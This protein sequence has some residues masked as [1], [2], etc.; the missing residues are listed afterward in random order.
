MVAVAVAVA[1]AVEVAVGVGSSPVTVKI[2]FPSV[3]ITVVPSLKRQRTSTNVLSPGAAPVFT[4]RKIFSNIPEPTRS[5]T[6]YMAA[7]TEPG[8]EALTVGFPQA[9]AMVPTTE[10]AA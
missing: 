2:P 4:F 3:V 7:R 6:P 1:V 8:V 5:S 9:S 10:V